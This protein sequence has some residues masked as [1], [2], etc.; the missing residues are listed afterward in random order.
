MSAMSPFYGRMYP[1]QEAP[2]VWE[3][4]QSLQNSLVEQS[5]SM[6]HSVELAMSLQEVLERNR[7]NY[8]NII[9]ERNEAYRRLQDADAKLQQV[10]HVVRRYAEVKDPV[11]ASDGYTYE[12]TELSRYLSDC[13]RSNSKAY[14]QQ[15]KEELTDVMVDNVSLRRLAD[16]LKGVHTVELPQLSSRMPLTSG[17]VDKN[18]PRTHWAEEDSSMCG[19]RHGEVGSGAVGLVGG[20]GGRSGNGVAMIH[21]HSGARFDRG[22]VAKSGKPCNDNES[23][24]GRHPCTRVYGFCNFE[25]DCTFANYPYEAC[26]NHIKGKCR[27]GSSCKELHVDPRDPVYQN[28]RSFANQHYNHGANN[29]NMNHMHSTGA[30]SNNTSSGHAADADAEVPT[31][32]GGNVPE[33]AAVSGS[34]RAAD[35]RDNYDSGLENTVSSAPSAAATVS[36][37]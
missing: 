18:G 12:R 25:D 14:S 16:L 24:G 1:T 26:L 34:D 33:T 21:G 10:E 32:S 19:M 3:A 4:T 9:A 37:E 17:D 7:E 8:N 28:P 29:A 2:L 20:A 27:F 13:K 11:V 30:G 36:A 23:K 15:T 22:G 5:R 6:R 31:Q 35:K